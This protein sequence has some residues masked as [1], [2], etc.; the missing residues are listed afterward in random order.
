MLSSTTTAANMAVGFINARA[1]V[2]S[3][4]RFKHSA[5]LNDRGS[6]L[7]NGTSENDSIRLVPA[8][9]GMMRIMIT[10]DLDD[11]SIDTVTT[12]AAKPDRESHVIRGQ[13]VIMVADE[14]HGIEMTTY[15][16]V[17]RASIKRIFVAGG[18]GDDSVK[19]ERLGYV[20]TTQNV[21]EVQLQQSPAPAEGKPWMPADSGVARNWE[22]RVA[23]ERRAVRDGDATLAFLGD[24]HVEAFPSTGKRSWNSL[25][26]GA[27]A[28]GIN[29]D[30]TRQLLYRIESGL[31]DRFR[32][33]RIVLMIGTNNLN[34]PAHAGTDDEIVRGME[35]VV[36]ALR[37]RL[38]E[39]KIVLVSIF[40]RREPGMNTR[41]ENVNRSIAKLADNQS[42]FFLDVYGH[43]A[44]APIRK[45][46]F[47]VDDGHLNDRGYRI[48]AARLDELLARIEPFPP[49]T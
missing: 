10:T 31:F 8:A 23:R 13:S 1:T 24:S 26:T 20:P 37:T 25:F 22:T 49:G 18:S 16:T 34:D 27:A 11:E 7:I 47:L 46:M 48:L 30:T 29:G 36:N 9:N 38:P 45:E 28:L 14:N 44:G 3:Q 32:P 21:E 19:V 4:P 42:L 17:P 41:I 5:I 2:I 33:D 15:F 35:A 12:V 39:T 6:L 43:Y 40:P